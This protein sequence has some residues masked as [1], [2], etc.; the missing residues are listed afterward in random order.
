MRFQVASTVRSAA[1]RNR[2]LSLDRIEVGAVGRQEEQLGAGGANSPAHG[3]ALVA[4]EIVDDDDVARF[5]DW[6]EN[7][8][9]IGQE[10]FA[11]NRP[12]D[13]TR[14]IDPVMAQG[15]QE[16]Q[17]SPVALRNLGQELA[18]TRRP[19]AQARHVGLGPGLVDK[20][21]ARGIKPP[22]VLSPLCPPPGDVRTILLAG[23]QAFF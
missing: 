21:K 8:L 2:A 13:D 18:S 10:A 22:L 12:V 14:G 5:E 19:T 11:V 4:A 23:V 16:G 15:R 3:L 1:F 20:D 9:D 17:R 6:N 7:L